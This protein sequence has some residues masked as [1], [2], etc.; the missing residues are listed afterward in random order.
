MHAPQLFAYQRIITSASTQYPPTA[1]LNYDTQFRMQH[2]APL[3]AGTHTTQ[4]FGCYASQQ[5]LCPLS[6]D[7][8]HIVEQPITA[9]KI[10]YFV[11][12]PYQQL[13]TGTDKLI[14]QAPVVDNIQLH[15]DY[16]TSDNRPAI[17][18]TAQFVTPRPNNSIPSPMQALRS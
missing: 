3:Y 18:T 17:P 7:H 16:P 6:A 4:T 13:L 14:S 8:V 2:Q 11:P 5:P 1:W 15:E 9:L 12:M 10:V